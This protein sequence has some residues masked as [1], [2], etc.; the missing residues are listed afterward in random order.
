MSQDLAII[1]LNGSE[2]L[3][4]LK[5]KDYVDENNYF[6]VKLEDFSFLYEVLD[7]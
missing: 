6:S 3:R 5:E 2:F 1:K 7:Y 4:I